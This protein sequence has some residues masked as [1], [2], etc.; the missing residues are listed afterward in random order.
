MFK[1]LSEEK[2]LIVEGVADDVK[3]SAV[4]VID[5]DGKFRIDN[6]GVSRVAGES[7]EQPV[8]SGYVSYNSTSDV[9]TMSGI[10]F[11]VAESVRSILGEIINEVKAN[12][13][14]EEV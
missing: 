6:S 1:V 14:A 8:P 9:L 4:V 13:I 7:G 2:R 12:Y 3:I 5:N 10:P 11:S